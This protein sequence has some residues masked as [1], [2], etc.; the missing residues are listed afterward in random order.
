MLHAFYLSTC[1]INIKSDRSWEGIIRIFHDDLEDALHHRFGI[2]PNLDE[3]DLKTHIENI[4]TYLNEHLFFTHK[5]EKAEYRIIKVV[6]HN[7]ILQILVSGKS[8]IERPLTIR[9]NLLMELFNSQ[10]NVM[11]IKSA[12][13]MTTLY[14]N[15]NSTSQQIE[16]L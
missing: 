16:A 10:K 9:N 11:T 15:K 4:Q 7:D 12:Q 2:R 14:F 13:E 1:E 3:E 8:W 6:R 5:Q